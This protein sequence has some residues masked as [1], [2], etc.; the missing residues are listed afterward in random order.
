MSQSLSLTLQAWG[1][2]EDSIYHELSARTLGELPDSLQ[3]AIQ[4]AERFYYDR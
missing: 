2:V 4:A 3:T 1:N